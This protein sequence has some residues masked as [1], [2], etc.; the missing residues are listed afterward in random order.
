LKPRL[1]RG[2]R[3]RRQS[4]AGGNVD[5]TIGATQAAIVA[6]RGGPG[7]TEADGAAIRAK[8]II[9]GLPPVIEQ[10]DSLI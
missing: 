2:T 8:Q 7:K 3:P 1:P 5:T 9:D 10:I 6:L 4:P